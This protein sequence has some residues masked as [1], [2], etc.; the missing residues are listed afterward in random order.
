MTQD[1]SFPWFKNISSAPWQ[2]VFKRIVLVLSYSFLIYK[3]ATFAHYDAFK[4]QFIHFNFTQFAWFGGVIILLPI[5]WLLESLKWKMLMSKLQHFSILKSMQSVFTGIATGFFTPNRVGEFA[6]RIA[7]VN[8]EFRKAGVTLSFMNS[9]TQNMTMIF[10]GIPA[11]L[12]FLYVRH[13]SFSISNEIYLIVM[14]FLG[15]IFTFLYF[16]F[17]LV[18][19][20][21]ER[22]IKHQPVLDFLSFLSEYS[23]YGLLKVLIISLIRYVIFSLQFYFMLR[24]WSVSL[25]SAQAAIAI[26]TSYLFVSFTPAFAFSE[27]AVRSS[28]A[29]LFIGAFVGNQ[30]AVLFA[31]LSIWL[32]NFA[33]PMLLGSWIW[34]RK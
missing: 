28:Y 22:K 9:L 25:T 23:L 17:P 4:L 27:P 3:L 13:S 2:R 5:N 29:V 15:I 26:P 34:M 33:I 21:L 7:F 14:L 24:F 12:T 19:P 18:I 16:G 10:C 31:A 20:Y 1:F 6:G 11:F 8:P 32:I 30:V